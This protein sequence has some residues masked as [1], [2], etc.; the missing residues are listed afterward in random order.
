MDEKNFELEQLTS[1]WVL[2]YNEIKKNGKFNFDTFDNAF[3]S[4]YQLLCQISTEPSIEK[5]FLS[6]ITNAYLFAHADVSVNIDSK[7]K[8]ALVLT[9]RM[10]DSVMAENAIAPSGESTIYILE[11]RKE[12]RINFNDINDSIEVLAKVF[13]ADYWNKISM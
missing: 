8:A 6:V 5:K 2:L 13:E 3:S 12:I 9:E 10:L 11:F 1:N 7:Y 4:T